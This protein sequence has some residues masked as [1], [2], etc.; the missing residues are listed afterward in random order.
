[1]C[2]KFFSMYLLGTA[3]LFYSCIDDTYDL[4]KEIAKD[5]RIEGNKLSIPLGSLNPI[6][7][8]SLL[9]LESISV[10]KVDSTTRSYSLSLNDDL[11]TRVAKNDLS[12]LKELSR[13]SSEIDPISISLGEIKLDMPTFE[14]KDTI[15]FKNLVLEDVSMKAIHEEATLPIEEIKLEPITINGEDFE[16]KF[17]IPEFD[18]GNIDVDE[19]ESQTASFTID[20]VDIETMSADGVKNTMTLEVNQIDMSNMATPTLTTAQ[21]TRLEIDVVNQTIARL[22]S[23]GYNQ[24]DSDLLFPIDEVSTTEGQV[25]VKFEYALPKEVKSLNEIELTGE[26]GELVDFMIVNPPLLKGLERK[27]SFSITFPENYELALY[28]NE[29]Y[30]LVDNTISVNAMSAEDDQTHL[31]F[32]I[33]RIKDLKD[34]HYSQADGTVLLQYEKPVSYTITYSVSGT[35]ELKK[36]TSFSQIT[37]GLTYS[38]A[39]NSSFDVAEVYGDINPVESSMHTENLDFS[40][41]IDNLSYITSV[42]RVELYPEQSKLIFKTQ[43]GDLGGFDLD[44][45][46]EIVLSFPVQ[47]EFAES[48]MVYPMQ[49]VTRMKDDAGRWTNDFRIKSLN[50]FKNQTWILPV[51]AVNFDCEVV[52]GVLN[53]EADASVYAVSGG[54]K[55]VLTIGGRTNLPLKSSTELLCQAHGITLEVEPINLS[56]KDVKGQMEAIEI[57]LEEETFDLNFEITNIDYIQAV[58]YI[59][60]DEG[61]TIIF[62]SKSDNSS[63]DEVK[64]VDGSYI[65]LY[66]PTEYKFSSNSNLEYDNNLKASY[67]KIDEFSELQNGRWELELERVD[68]VNG[69]V[70]NETL[71]FT[72][73]VTMLAVNDKAVNNTLFIKSGDDGEFSL[74]AMK[75]LFGE[76]NVTFGVDIPQVSIKDMEGELGNI[77]VDFEGKKVDYKISLDSL[78]YISHVENIDLKAGYNYF[79]FHGE[80]PEALSQFN[81]APNSTIDFVFPAD[82]VL[83]QANSRVPQ[84]VLFV[85]N[86]NIVRITDLKALDKEWELA[87]RSIIIDT[88]IKNEK[89]NKEYTIDIVGRKANGEKGLTVTAPTFKLST[90]READGEGSIVVS[91]LESQIEIED[92]KAAIGDMDF[93]F[94]TQT[95]DFPVNIDGLD[96]VQEIKYIT[97]KEGHNKINF[98]ISLS[99][100][101]GDLELAENSKLKIA[102]PSGIVLGDDSDFS[103]LDYRD[104]ALYID[105][106]ASLENCHISLEV[107]TL[108]I[109]QEITDDAFDWVGS[110]VISAIN[111]DTDTEGTLYIAGMEALLSE[112]QDVMGDKT[113]VFDMPA[114]EMTIDEAVMLTSMIEAEL[115]EVVEIPLDETLSEPIDRIDAIGFKNPVE[116]TMKIIAEGLESV[117]VPLHLNLDIA[118]PSVFVLNSDDVEVTDEGLHIETSHNFMKD[119]NCIELTMQIEKLDFTQLGEGCLVLTKTEGN[120]R[121]LKYDSQAKIE[122]KAWIDGALLS[123]DFLSSDLTLDVAFEMGEM[124]LKDF[125]GIYG[126]TIDPVIET[127]TLGVENGLGD[128]EENGLKLSNAK[129]ELMVSLYNTIGVPVDVDLA[130][131]G[132]DKEG[133]PIGSASIE[134]NDL[135]IKPAVLNEEGILEKATTQWLFT[136][137]KDS[138]MEG[139]E[140]IH[141]PNLDSLLN[142]LPY[143]IEFRLVPQIVTEETTHHVD[144]SQ[145][146]ELGGSYAISVPFDLEFS[147]SIPLEFGAEADAILRNDKN[148][149]TLAN[150]Q[151][152][153]S[154]HNPIAADLAFDLSII[155]KNE[156]GETMES[157]SFVFDD[158]FVL[159]AGELQEDGSVAPKATRWLFAVNDSITRQ[160]YETKVTPALGTLLDELPHNIDVALNAHFNTDLTTKIDYENDLELVCEY[161]VLVPLQFND[162]HLNYID[163]I[164]EIKLNLE[165]TLIEMGL[166]VTDI[167]LAIGMNLKSTL[168]LGLTLNLV[169]LDINGNVVEEIEIASIELPVGDG[170]EIGNGDT[171]EGVPVELSIKCASSADLSKLDKIMF[172]LDVASGNGEKTLSGLQGLQICDIVLQIMCDFEMELSK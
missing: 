142:E 76:H 164:S 134:A 96:M 102:F 2:R 53:F 157:A 160:G 107:D 66:F 64:F 81:L 58:D 67:I 133:S 144:L 131:V 30:K 159:A 95:F 31:R 15:S 61:Q 77:D 20:E 106:I 37:D 122:G 13:L 78:K 151:L 34:Y 52:N 48:G 1:M 3:I 150:P 55:Q 166:T 168:P 19:I 21:A 71:N 97:F 161:G 147:Q 5:V 40:F 171:I 154:I 39:L 143:A 110:I 12:A 121:L 88:E 10:L 57:P 75:S 89:F 129:P 90:L 139:Y 136:S 43:I 4:R 94:A 68:M 137:N 169:P 69:R 35:A 87:V 116:M 119:G 23:M 172:Q 63:L 167:E 93:D 56:V 132:C 26:K 104:H 120:N 165:E 108:Y 135:H 114:T 103:G 72:S 18:I 148:S 170:S 29:N 141:I 100:S 73:M 125:S 101:L 98:S 80:L 99:S 83:D 109:N 111:T 11:V 24:L 138:Q 91:V 118:I 128:L 155:G 36:G 112:M 126:G 130:I 115:S 153:L 44:E 38:L 14:K 105:K 17:E 70:D 65:A 85:A 28:D 113:V 42:D 27:V 54:K 32:Y 60:F 149:L 92:I 127:F 8:D 25:D 82:F 47:Y 16:S 146:L 124:I 22:E 46:S 50:A 123:S 156:A 145:N 45:Q 51:N 33:K 49:H 84:G 62:T 152:A 74:E 7:L 79:K 86:E 162:L 59:E 158:S 117:D 163:T 6:V 140:T 9:D 41:T